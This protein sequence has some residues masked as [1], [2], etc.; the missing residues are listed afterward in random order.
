[1]SRAYPGY[2]EEVLRELTL[3][4]ILDG[5]PDGDL[6]LEVGMHGPPDVESAVRLIERW[7]NL[8]RGGARSKPQVR[9]VTDQDNQVKMLEEILKLLKQLGVTKP[10]YPVCQGMKCFNCGEEGYF[11]KDCP[12]KPQL[13]N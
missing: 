6:K 3:K 5:L 4:A 11:K 1:M 2:P 9:A 8:Q 12:N 10:K 7:E 13:G